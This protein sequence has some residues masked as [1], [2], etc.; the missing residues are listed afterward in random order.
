ML[1]T[2][3]TIALICTLCF[4]SSTHLYADT[5]TATE[6]ADNSAAGADSAPTTDES[7]VPNV[8]DA[9]PAEVRFMNR[10]VVTFRSAIS[11]TTATT[12]AQRATELLQQLSRRELTL[13]LDT[14]DVSINNQ[15]MV[16]FRLGDRLLFLLTPA[17]A[18]PD[19]TRDFNAQIHDVQAH[20]RTVLAAR[21]EFGRWRNI[22]RGLGFSLAATA[23]LGGLIK[24]LMTARA[25]LQ[26]RLQ[27]LV[28]RHREAFRRHNVDWATSAL[29]LIARVLHLLMGLLVL[30]LIY[31]WL[32]FVLKQFVFTQ[33]L[34]DRLGGFFI[35]LLL[36]IGQGM[37]N[38]IPGL[39][40]VFVIF[41]LAKAF[42]DLL[43]NFFD[44]VA[45]GS[46]S[47]PGIHPDTI[48]ATRRISSVLVWVLA[49]T[50]AYPYI[51]GSQTNI[52]KGLS[53]LAGLILTLGSS[54]IVN[55][56]M[57]GMTLIY[58][59]S[60]RKGD[61]VQIGEVIGV[62]E[63]VNALSVKLLRLREE[64]TVP[65]AVVVGNTVRN[66]SRLAGGSSVVLSAT[67]TIGYDAP[68]RQVHALLI[69]AAAS[70]DG[71]LQKPT[72]LVLQ[73]ALSDFYVEYELQVNVADVLHF[74]EITSQ[75][76]ANI[77]DCFN[78]SGVQIMSP[79]FVIQPT[80]SV[81]VPKENWS[82]DLAKKPR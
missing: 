17:D 2:I 43:D 75:L 19:D 47:F 23:V 35:S 3:R 71:V 63:E 33:P 30:T 77:Q 60:M 49:L 70:T 1:T 15:T 81:V 29:Q 48:D 80:E 14:L 8:E 12:R 26:I 59:R 39:I 58:S 82:E 10:T 7:A 32:T 24:L 50:F 11:G 56:L 18:A 41:V 34:G 36:Q 66:Y 38:A 53:V 68:W 40:T 61:L 52:F 25:R 67:V 55:Q 45:R 69:A 28:E 54:G 42:H 9:G 27:R 78:E 57:S 64:I 74:L 22:L 37:L 16:A 13:P 31:G 21:S 76:H 72:P 46:L 79:H 6:T 73:R 4:L 20:L 5:T 62:V 51:P 65:N 44:N